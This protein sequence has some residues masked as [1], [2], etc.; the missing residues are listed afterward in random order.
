MYGKSACT[1]PTD[2]RACNDDA[3]GGL[4]GRRGM[5]GDRRAG[6]PQK[7]R[8][9]MSDVMTDILTAFVMLWL[10]L[11]A[12]EADARIEELNR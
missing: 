6:R 12:T 5:Y 3:P 4:V 11:A 10:L 1:R 2:G 8:D 9:S 7:G